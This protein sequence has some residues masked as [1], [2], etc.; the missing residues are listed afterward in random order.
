[1]APKIPIFFFLLALAAGVQGETG[2]VGGG[3]GNVEYNC[4]YTVF[5]RTG[6]AWKGGTDS[7]IGVE[8]AGADGRGVRIADLERWGGLMGAG[9]DYYERGNLDVFSGRGPCLPA[10][11]CWMNLTS[12][13]AGA[14]H[15]WYCNYVEVTATGPHRGCAQRRFDVEQWLATDASPYRLTAVRDQCRGHAAA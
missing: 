7:T 4:V 10:A 8:F 5:V 14:H 13:G 15:G 11:P 6:S 12:D 9:H 2:G 3:G 1:M